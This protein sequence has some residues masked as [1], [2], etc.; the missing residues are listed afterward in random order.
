MAQ[1]HHNRRGSVTIEQILDSAEEVLFSKGVSGL[2][3][4]AVA[5]HAGISK[6]GLLHHFPSKGVLE[7]GIE[8]RFVQTMCERISE[9]TGQGVSFLSALVAEMKSC[10]EQDG[11][12]LAAFTLCASKEH[13]PA[14]LQAF[15]NKLLTCVE[16][17]HPQERYRSLVFF[18]VI[19]LLLSDV[20][21]LVKLSDG[22]TQEFYAAVEELVDEP[23]PAQRTGAGEG[24][25]KA[26][27]VA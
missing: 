3:L 13:S 18:A 21:H 26:I 9:R 11:R 20:W 19:G 17:N 24:A 16:Q 1:G 6:G 22:E 27:S 14:A 25:V 5:R 7:T 10:H 4:E 8:Q 12:S 23:S 15:G 2:T